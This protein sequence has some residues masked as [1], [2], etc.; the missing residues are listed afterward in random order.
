M[1]ISSCAAMK[2][3]GINADFTWSI[4]F[5]LSIS[6][7]ALLFIVLLIKDIVTERTNEGS[8]VYSLHKSSANSHKE[9]KPESKT[10]PAI[11]GSL[12]ACIIAVIAPIDLP[13][14]PIVLTNSLFLK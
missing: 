1:K 2:K 14:N 10:S 13:H 11:E 5:S 7:S 12:S 3:A 4:G 8:F 9:L 6:N